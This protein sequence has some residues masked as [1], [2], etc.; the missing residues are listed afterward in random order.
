MRARKVWRWPRQSDILI[1]DAIDHEAL[2]EYLRPWRPEE[3]HVRGEQIN[4]PVFWAGFV[5]R[6]G[7]PNFYMDCFIKKVRPRLIV[8]ATDNS[9]MFYSISVRHPDIKTLFVQNGIRAYKSNIFEI[10]DRKNPADG[11][12]KVDYM[13]TFGG[14]VGA[15]YAKY[16]QGAV[17]PM[18][19]IKN[20]LVPKHHAR[21]TGIIAYV[22]QFRQNH[23]EFLGQA[24]K[25]V[26]VFLK[27]YSEQH[28]KELYIVPC[29][30]YCG[31]DTLKKEKEYYNNM[32][33]QSCL[34]YE[35]S[36]FGS[37][38]VSIDSAEVVVG[39]D[40]T[41]VYESAAR[42]NKTAIFS[43]RS[44]LIGTAD[45]SYGWPGTY[46]DTGPYW[47][48]CPD[49]TVF[50]RIMDHLFAIDD[51]QWLAELRG[52]GF[53]DIMLYDPGNTILQSVLQMEFGPAPGG[54]A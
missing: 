43:I 48:N 52:H 35:W 13:M 34:F 29:S 23:R 46:Q 21:K 11:P 53:P 42:G 40:S 32:L 12:L 49:P 15:E 9:A 33:G 3:L 20:N 7:N 24:D 4:I 17:V 47:T 36:W 37:S 8:T 19:S 25:I 28:G 30:G 26:L 44:N 31:D 5:R 27:E 39:I 1:F 16:I 14:R 38:Y 18:G 6:S 54:G 22:S 2:L 41:L 45:R 51:A 10:L 50:K